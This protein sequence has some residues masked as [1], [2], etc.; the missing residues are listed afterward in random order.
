MDVAADE[1]LDEIIHQTEFQG[2]MP[3]T[4]DLTLSRNDT[5]ARARG[6]P[7]VG[8]HAAVLGLVVARGMAEGF[9]FKISS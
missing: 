2:S 7:C 5:E 3:D 8:T 4:V 1:A 9:T 6:W